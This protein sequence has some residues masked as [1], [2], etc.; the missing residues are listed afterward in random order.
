MSKEKSK[1]VEVTITQEFSISEPSANGPRTV[2]LKPGDH[3]TVPAVEGFYWV[4]RN[5]A[6]EGKITVAKKAAPAAEPSK[7]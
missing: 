7:K 1:L 6:V 2:I 5:L 3:R 4:K